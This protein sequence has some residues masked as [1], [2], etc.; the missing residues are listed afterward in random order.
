LHGNPAGPGDGIPDQL[1][2]LLPGEIHFPAAREVV[3]VA[4]LDGVDDLH[5][6]SLGREP[7]QP[8]TRR[9]QASWHQE[10]AVCQGIRSSKVVKQPA[11][12]AGAPKGFLNALYVLLGFHI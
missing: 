4:S 9:N 6:L 7:V 11:V 2:E 5:W 10:D 3:Q 8:A 1:M 12:E